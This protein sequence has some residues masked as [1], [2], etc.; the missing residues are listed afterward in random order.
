MATSRSILGT[1]GEAMV[2]SRLLFAGYNV[3]LPTCPEVYDLI[4]EKNKKYKRIQ[5]KSSQYNKRNYYEFNARRRD[6]KYKKGDVDFIVFVAL[7]I[8]TCWVVPFEKIKNITKININPK[9]A[10]GRWTIYQ[11][12]WKLFNRCQKK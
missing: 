6:G 2:A 12:K 10:D 9:K 8:Q 5:V 4:A 3:L 7:P 11:E 1:S